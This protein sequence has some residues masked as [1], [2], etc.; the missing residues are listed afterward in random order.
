MAVAPETK[1]L[2]VIEMESPPAPIP[3]AEDNEDIVGAGTLIEVGE[4]M[5]M[6]Q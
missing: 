5:D 2:P 3:T 6:V 1:W 4:V